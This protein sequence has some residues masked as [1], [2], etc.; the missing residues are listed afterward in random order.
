MQQ[1]QTPWQ[2]PRPPGAWARTIRG[3]VLHHTGG[4]S[5]VPCHSAGSWHYLIDRDGTIYQDVPEE[6]VAWHCRATDRWKPEWVQRGCQWAAASDINTCTIGIELVSAA[7]TTP[8][9][10]LQHV[11]LRALAADLATRYGDLWYVGHGEV[12]TDRRTSEPDNL[13]WTAIGCGPF[14]PRN[15]RPWHLETEDDMT[16]E[17]HALIQAIRETEYPPAEAEKLVRM[18][19]TL[20]ATAASVELWINEIGAL[21]EKLKEAARDDATDG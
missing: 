21:Q 3:V 12:Q 4:M 18:F 15:G 8:I 6:A 5:P 13:D 1:R 19:Q 10:D 20:N 2:T 9:T 17:E 16:P 7:G 14:D 11:A